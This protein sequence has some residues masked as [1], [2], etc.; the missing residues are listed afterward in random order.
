[1]LIFKRLKSFR[2]R[3]LFFIIT[4]FAV[5]F[6][7]YL[8]MKNVPILAHD[9]YCNSLDAAYRAVAIHIRDSVAE[10]DNLACRCEYDKWISLVV[11]DR[12]RLEQTR[13]LWEDSIN[14]NAKKDHYWRV[15]KEPW[16]L[17]TSEPK[18]VSLPSLPVRDSEL[19]NWWDTNLRLYIETNQ[20]HND[21]NASL[22]VGHNSDV[23]NTAHWTKQRTKRFF[24]GMSH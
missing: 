8:K 23:C 2:L 24:E 3:T 17:L 13:E 1:M 10:R 21:V 20:L 6:T 5:C 22:T 9:H 7:A 19:Q 11:R 4:A 16:R 14:S 15:H 18:T 12:E